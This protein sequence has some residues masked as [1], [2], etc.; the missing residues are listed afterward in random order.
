MSNDQIEPVAIEHLVDE[1]G[2]GDRLG[3]RYNFLD[4]HFEREGAYCRARSYTEEFGAAVL[5]GPFERRGS[6]KAV[7]NPTMQR[8]ALAYLAR[9]FMDVS[10]R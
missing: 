8:D 6:I 7:D 4:Y 2:D 1:V 9:R 10:V 5:F 3:Q